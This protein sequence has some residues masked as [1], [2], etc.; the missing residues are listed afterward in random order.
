MFRDAV[1]IAQMVGPGSASSLARALLHE[2]LVLFDE[3]AMLRLSV[4]SLSGPTLG[5]SGLLADV[6]RRA[7]GNRDAG[8]IRDAAF[9]FEYA[10]AEHGRAVAGSVLYATSLVMGAATSRTAMLGEARAA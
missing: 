6:A 5:P 3:A 7:L 4:A 9:G 10:A 1:R 8:Q 2:A